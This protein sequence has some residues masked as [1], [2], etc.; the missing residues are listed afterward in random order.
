MNT[1]IKHLITTIICLAVSTLPSSAMDQPQ[2]NE[3]QPE[4]TVEEQQLKIAKAF[5][6]VFLEKELARQKILEIDSLVT[7]NRFEEAIAT[8]DELVKSG[9]RY[10]GGYKVT[11]ILRGQAHYHY[12]LQEYEQTINIYTRLIESNASTISDSNNLV[13]AVYFYLKQNNPVK[14]ETHRMPLIQR[15]CEIVLSHD[16]TA[17]YEA[18]KAQMVLKKMIG[19]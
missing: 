8:Y 7:N 13:N 15:S 18:H 12:C 11:P 6:K 10:V 16:Y 2:H 5:E 14:I 19:D 17:Y 1:Q 4:K 9:N 3:P